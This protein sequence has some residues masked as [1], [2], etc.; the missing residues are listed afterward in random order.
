M[1]KGKAKKLNLSGPRIRFYRYARGLSQRQFAMELNFLGWMIDRSG[2]AKI[3]A[4]LVWLGDFQ[5]FYFREIFS[6]ELSS[7]LPHVHGPQE[8]FYDWLEK[9]LDRP[10]SNEKAEH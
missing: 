8:N 3:E 4:Q 6:V 10:N 2:V 1:A 5:L 7:L 9:S